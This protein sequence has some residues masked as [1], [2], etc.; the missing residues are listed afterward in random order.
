M[1]VAS[2]DDGADAS[3]DDGSDQ[4]MCVC[5]QVFKTS[6]GLNCHV[7]RYCKGAPPDVE[8]AEPLDMPSSSTNGGN[9]SSGFASLLFTAAFIGLTKLRLKF[10]ASNAQ[11]QS[12]KDMVC[13]LMAIVQRELTRIFPACHEVDT[14]DVPDLSEFIGPISDVFKGLRTE[15]LEGRAREA[16]L[17]DLKPTRRVLGKRY[18]PHDLPDGRRVHQEVEDVVYDFDA[19]K[20]LQAMFEHVPD[21]CADFL[22]SHDRWDQPL[23][24]TISDVCHGSGLRSSPLFLAAKST[25]RFPL[26]LHYYM[27][28]I[29]LT[30]PLAQNAGDNKVACSYVVVLNF[31]SG[32]RTSPHCIIPVSVCFEKDWSRYEEVDIVS[33]PVDESYH[34]SSFGAQM[35]RLFDGIELKCPTQFL[36]DPRVRT[37]DDGS[38]FIAVSGGLALTS[39]DAPAG[40]TLRG[41]KIAFGPLTT[42]ICD[43]CYCKQIDGE[44]RRAHARCN[45]FLPWVRTGAGEAGAGSFS[46][47]ICSDAAMTTAFDFNFQGALQIHKARTAESTL[48]DM[49]IHTRLDPSAQ[50]WFKQQIGVRTFNHSFSRMPYGNHVQIAKDLMHAELLGNLKEHQ[51]KMLWKMKRE[52]KWITDASAFNTRV[53]SFPHW[54]RGSRR[55]SYLLSDDAFS[56]SLQDCSVGGLWTAHNEMLFVCYSIELLHV[57]VPSGQEEHPVWRC[58]CL[59]YHY[60]M[61]CLQKEFT[62]DDIR[63]LDQTI[64]DFQALYLEVYGEESWK[65]KFNFAQHFPLE[66]LK[67]D[68]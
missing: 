3:A 64:Y 47:L 55:R 20:H 13:E 39:A 9:T 57:F 29:G 16:L 54:A 58:W 2:A 25:G 32:C 38:T 17:P 65:P 48:Q 41:T 28:G 1:A 66:I 12:V 35:R 67:Y 8:V 30:N 19:M 4:F 10:N 59:H 31:S 26:L 60:I 62:L 22:A 49:Q 42:A 21:L 34:G 7:S 56:G 14:E 43:G 36:H 61:L 11:V 18:I 27:D 40:G 53:L 33:G 46:G 45:S 6:R 44:N 51:S 68:S 24:G 15:Y 37:R 5:R 52:L 63:E 23:Q 50:E